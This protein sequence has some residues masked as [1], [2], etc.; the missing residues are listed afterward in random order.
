MQT[1]QIKPEK[2]PVVLS[3]DEQAAFEIGLRSEATGKDYSLEE[4]MQFARESRKIW[5]KTP[6]AVSA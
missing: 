6:Q 3:P 4:V 2:T 1:T 5:K